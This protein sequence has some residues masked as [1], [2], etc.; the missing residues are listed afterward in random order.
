LWDMLNQ[1]NQ[2]CRIDINDQGQS[3]QLSRSD[4]IRD[5]LPHGLGGGDRE[6]LAPHKF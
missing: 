6:R 4:S 1:I 2:R 5:R 3:P